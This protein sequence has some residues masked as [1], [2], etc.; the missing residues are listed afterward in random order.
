MLQR[1]GLNVSVRELRDLADELD[2][3]R[4]EENNKL[5]INITTRKKFQ[6]NIINKSKCSDTWVIEK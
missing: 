1:Q 6:I 4:L 3:E 5:G 2:K